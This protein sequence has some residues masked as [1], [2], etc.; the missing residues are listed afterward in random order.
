M[1][2]GRYCIL[3][4]RAPALRQSASHW[5]ARRACCA[6]LCRPLRCTLRLL[7]ATP[8]PNALHGVPAAQ[9]S[10][11]TVYY[12]M[13][14]QST[15][16]SFK[17][18]EYPGVRQGQGAAPRGDFWVC[19]GRD[20]VWCLFVTV[21]GVGGEVGWVRKAHM[22]VQ[23]PC[24]PPSVPVTSSV[25]GVGLPV[26]HSHPIASIRRLRPLDPLPRCTVLRRAAPCC[27]WV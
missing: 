13:R 7:P 12:A 23:G 3:A 1:W 17:F 21:W 15:V 9:S 8:S 5:T 16:G 2:R 10:F 25:P 18:I 6:E 4:G 24:A 11:K 19:V 26:T 14:I 20:G 22:Q 27:R